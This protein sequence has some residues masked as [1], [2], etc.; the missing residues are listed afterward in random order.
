MQWP[1]EAIV[2][3]EDIVTQLVGETHL[4]QPECDEGLLPILNLVDSLSSNLPEDP[5]IQ[6]IVDSIEATLHPLLEE[7]KLF[8][9]HSIESLK[10]ASRSLSDHLLALKSSGDVSTQKP[11]PSPLETPVT[12]LGQAV[13]TSKSEAPLAVTPEPIRLTGDQIVLFDKLA[14]Q[15]S[16]E[17]LLTESGSDEGI[18][19]IYSIL[20][21]FQSEFESI[22]FVRSSLESVLSLMDQLVDNAQAFEDA[23]LALL[24]EFNFWLETARSDVFQGEAPP[25]FEGQLP[26]PQTSEST[27]DPTST[28][29]SPANSSDPFTEFDVVLDLNLE[30]NQELLSEFHIEAVDHLGQIETAVLE[31]EQESSSKEAID[32]MFRSFHTIKGV[33]GFLNLVPV[34]RLAHEVESLID[35]VRQSK[36]PIFTGVI[37]L[38]L[39]SKDILECHIEQIST[40][41]NEGATPIEV[42]PVSPL[43]NRARSAM[44]GPEQYAQQLGVSVDSVSSQ[45]RSGSPTKAPQKKTPETS[46]IRVSTS[47]LDNL[48]DTV[49]ELVIVY[50]QIKERTKKGANDPNALEQSL[51]QLSRITKDLQ[52]TST[53][54]R[55]V[56]IKST[57][58]KMSRIARDTSAQVGKKSVFEISGEDTEIDRKVVEEIGDPL[59]HMIRNAIDHGLELTE[60]RLACGKNEAGKVTLKA[61]RKGSN[62]VIE[63][64]DDGRGIDPNRILQKAIAHGI[65]GKHESLL[66]EEIFQLILAPGFS[67]AEE[68]SDIS[69]RGVGMDVVR[70]NIEKLRGKIE[71]ESELGKGS[72]FRILLPLTMA[73]VD[74]LIVKVGNDRF[75]LPVASV[76]VALRPGAGSLTLAEGNR[77]TLHIRE[78]S[79]PLF[80]LHRHFKIPNAQTNPEKAAVVI[81]ESNSRQHGFLVDELVGKQEDVIKSLGS[82]MNKIPGVSGG[83]ILGDGTIALVIDPTT[84]I[85]DK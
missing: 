57:F 71:I 42:I 62:V 43:M 1:E 12:D 7:A 28:P 3:L 74:G 66:Q 73:I 23:S 54:L 26:T 70:Q 8:D 47:K 24:T 52:Q 64:A 37:D 55:L 79:Y 11:T 46:S 49:S 69:G 77:E 17:L 15:F 39:D 38:V 48:M 60:D 20:N 21:E 58:Q 81:V 56:P 30:E 45:D 9:T 44:E 19:P 82:L 18:L 22:P 34:N 5:H 40:A 14:H 59:V 84:L 31:L 35:L 76:K 65:V 72:I 50:S 85:E 78:E 41:L 67:T 61:Y 25:I 4:A 2:Q 27:P 29:P 83:S 10:T 13:E 51:A 6:A 16:N 33:A 68:V 32:S 75:V 80:R 36:I 53:S 63:L